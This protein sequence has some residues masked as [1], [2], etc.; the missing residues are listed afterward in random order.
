MAD[1]NA[2]SVNIR[3]VSSWRRL[4]AVATGIL[5]LS[6]SVYLWGYWSYFDINFL[7]YLS[8]QDVVAYTFVGVVPIVGV[9]TIILVWVYRPLLSKKSY[10]W[11]E[12]R[13]IARLLTFGSLVVAGVVYF[14]FTL[15]YVD[16]PAGVSFLFPGLLCAVCF[17]APRWFLSD[18]YEGEKT[19]WGTSGL[20]IGITA[21]ALFWWGR[22]EA[23]NCRRGMGL[24]QSV[25]VTDC[26]D[27]INKR[28][29]GHVYVGRLG[30]F[31]FVA[32]K[33]RR[34][35]LAIPEGRTR[36]IDISK[37]ES[38]SHAMQ[39]SALLRNVLFIAVCL[40]AAILYC[41]VRRRRKKAKHDGEAGKSVGKEEKGSEEG[42]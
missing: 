38:V 19:V 39:S 14:F 40:Y 35:T 2:S 23:S 31:V 34:E 29:S 42:S 24:V 21:L 33:D 30:G 28:I 16:I 12:H 8:I 41:F 10:R 22:Y 20:I 11:I 6:A 5:L 3:W 4:L 13:L 25:L 18:K 1:E 37:G 17:N 26:E 7:E 27:D 36:L 9:M 32:A 15:V